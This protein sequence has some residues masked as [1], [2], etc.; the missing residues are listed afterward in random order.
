MGRLGVRRR[1]NTSNRSG[2]PVLLYHRDRVSKQHLDFTAREQRRTQAQVDSNIA[3]GRTDQR[4]GTIPMLRYCF[5]IAR[6]F[7]AA[8]RSP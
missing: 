8:W 4:L 2:I 3:E 6:A 5:D 7:A 1:R